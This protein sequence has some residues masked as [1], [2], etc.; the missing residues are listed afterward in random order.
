MNEESSPL[1]FEKISVSSR[2]GLNLEVKFC[3][4]IAI[5]HPLRTR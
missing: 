2:D 4:P 3:V 5:R 1:P